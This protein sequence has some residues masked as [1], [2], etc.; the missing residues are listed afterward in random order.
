LFEASVPEVIIEIM[1]KHP[2][3]KSVQVGTLLDEMLKRN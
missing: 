3:E 1:K 2:D